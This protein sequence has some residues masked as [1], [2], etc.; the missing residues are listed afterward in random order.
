MTTKLS[1]TSRDLRRLCAVA[2]PS[3]L[4]GPG[5]LMPSSVLQ[6]LAELVPCDAVTYQQ[7]DPSRPSTVRVQELN[8]CSD[9]TND[10]A[11][12]A[13]FFW[14]RVWPTSGCDYPQR[15]GDFTTVHR[16]SDFHS[17]REFGASPTAEFFRLTGMRCEVMMPLPPSGPI[18]H[19][20]MLWRADSRDFTDRE[21]LLLT[22]L[23]PHLA[24]LQHSVTRRDSGAAGLTAR[25]LDVLRLVAEGHTNLQ[26]ARRLFLSEG[27]VRRHLE[28][29]F[30]RLNV[31]SRMAAVATVFPQ[32]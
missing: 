20:I 14:Q 5:D 6:S 15:T 28:N 32:G 19:R 25:Q 18:D 24:A 11:E 17:P 4:D 31:N 3:Q 2:D 1:V 10:D 29:V 12:F 27:T 23:R 21:T 22:L 7:G 16:I 8:P 9:P 30:D 13:A 26:I